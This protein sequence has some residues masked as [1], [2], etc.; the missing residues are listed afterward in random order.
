[1]VFTCLDWGI[2][3]CKCVGLFLWKAIYWLKFFWTVFNAFKELFFEC[4][5]QILAGT[6]TVRSS[7]TDVVVT[8]NWFF[9][10]LLRTILTTR[11]FDWKLNLDGLLVNL[12]QKFTDILISDFME[13]QKILILLN[14]VFWYD[15]KPFLTHVKFFLSVSKLF[16]F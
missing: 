15:L 1:M 4:F 10:L 12:F 7:F 2:D 3:L 13:R 11:V 9:V 8:S 5:I 16:I 6:A 14:W